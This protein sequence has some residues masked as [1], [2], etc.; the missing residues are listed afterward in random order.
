MLNECIFKLDC[1]DWEYVTMSI[2]AHNYPAIEG[3]D[4]HAALTTLSDIMQ[5]WMPTITHAQ[6][7]R[8]KTAVE[9]P[10]LKQAINT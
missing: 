1:I 8:L 3:I 5:M 6:K 2:E 10:I 4:R 7:H 9:G